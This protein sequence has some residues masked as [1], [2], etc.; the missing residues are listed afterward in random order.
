MSHTVPAALIF[1]PQLV[2]VVDEEWLMEALPD[3]GADCL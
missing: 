1:D 3:D 2:D